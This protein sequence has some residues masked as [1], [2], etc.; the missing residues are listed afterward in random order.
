MKTF[1]L[2]LSWSVSRGQDTYGYNICRLDDS[3]TGKRY[4]C[5]GGGY[6]MV[7][8]V[9]AQWLQ[10]RFQDRLKE[11]SHRAHATYDFHTSPRTREDNPRPDAL[12]G[13]ACLLGL[14]YSDKKKGEYPS[15]QIDGACGVSSVE[16]V[17]EA[18]GLTIRY[19]PTFG[20]SRTSKGFIVTDTRAEA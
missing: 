19:M 1:I 9:L 3:E 2:H 17:A 16:R 8:T 5:N 13:L 7:G 10:D 15:M 11:L 20:R 18:I 6:D 4:R 14:S 12:Y